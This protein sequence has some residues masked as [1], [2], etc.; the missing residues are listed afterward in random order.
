MIYKDQLNK[1]LEINSPPQKIISL[2]PSQTE[3]L[4]DLGL[5]DKIIGITKFCV[6]PAH[7]KKTKEIIGGTKNLNIEKIISLQPDL[8]I[9][10]K[11]ENAQQQIAELEKHFQV[12]TSDIKTFEDAL[13]MIG[14]IANITSTSDKAKFLTNNIRSSKNR[15]PTA[16][17]NCP[18]AVY[19]IWKD[20]Y[21]TV[22]GDTFISD[23]MQIAGF[24]NLFGNEKRYPELTIDVITEKSPEIIMLSSEPYPF[25]QLHIDALQTRLPD[26]KICLVDGEMFSWYGSRMLYAFDYFIQLRNSF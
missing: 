18:L 11:E 4:F 20:P 1:L 16:T 21:M 8:I 24:E 2:V 5:E 6:H 13:Q 19:L 22:G 26:S 9:A 7:L 12:W 25:N 23:M 3:L 10:N 15:L 17:A 14:M